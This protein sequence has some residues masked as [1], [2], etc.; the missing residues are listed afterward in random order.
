MTHTPQTPGQKQQKEPSKFLRAI[1]IGL[2]LGFSAVLLV[3]RIL[4]AGEPS[5]QTISLSEMRAS[6]AAL[7]ANVPFG[8]PVEAKP[9]HTAEASATAKGEQSAKEAS[10]SP[11]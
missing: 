1:F 11:A 3:P 9:I 2:A 4:P 6:K 8:A 5:Q 7:M 10:N